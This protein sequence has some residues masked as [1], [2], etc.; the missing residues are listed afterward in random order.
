MSGDRRKIE[1]TAVDITAVTQC[2]CTL[3]AHEASARVVP[4]F[5][6]VN[7]TVNALQ[8]LLLTGSAFQDHQRSE[9]VLRVYSTTSTEGGK[10]KP[11]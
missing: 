7:C 10:K 3:F 1:P 6:A 5:E 11:F 2:D 4:T 9:S 8:R